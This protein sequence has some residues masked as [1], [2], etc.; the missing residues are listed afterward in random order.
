MIY[1]YNQHRHIHIIERLKK[2][3]SQ[4]QCKIDNRYYSFKL[5]DRKHFESSKK[6][7]KRGKIQKEDEKE[8]KGNKIKKRKKR[9]IGRAKR[10][11]DDLNHLLEGP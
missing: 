10:N 4:E 1:I 9:K 5:L 2:L 7:E 3:Q 8:K 11:R 6:V